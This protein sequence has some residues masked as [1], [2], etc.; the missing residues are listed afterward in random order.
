MSKTYEIGMPVGEPLQRGAN[1]WRIKLYQGINPET[2]KP[3][4]SYETVR[5]TKADADV[6]KGELI[7]LARQARVVAK[8]IKTSVD[9]ALPLY[10]YCMAD[11]DAREA[12][13]VISPISA[14]TARDACKALAPYLAGHTLESFDRDAAVELLRDLGRRKPAYS[15]GYIV[16]LKKRLST[17]LT[18]AVLAK[19]VQSHAFFKVKTPAL[20][21]SAGKVIATNPR[22][23]LLAHLRGHA[24]GPVVRFLLAT[25]LRRAE[26]CAILWSDIN[27]ETRQA[28]VNKGL[29]VLRGGKRYLSNG[30]TAAARRTIGLPDATMADLQTLFAKAQARCE[31]TGEIVEALPVFTNASG[32]QWVPQYLYE[33][34]K[35]VLIDCRLGDH[36]LHD[37]RHT[38]AT[39][40][41]Q[42]LP[43]GPVSRRL[44][45]SSAAITLSIYEHQL[46]E[47]KAVG[48]VAAARLIA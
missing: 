29:V 14:Q 9:A 7:V 43:A 35:E 10:D 13:R 47:E 25:G 11:I 20:A 40:M 5:G 19:H 44:G 31:Q 34:V 33:K 46:P 36:R 27:W 1:S 30:K 4:Y 16:F 37:L 22:A 41:L 32:D 18:R 39:E 15:N 23:K 42:S 24:M 12:E 21:R 26:V 45:H 28:S 48:Q 38:M 8:A 3:K 2:S 6:R 17:V